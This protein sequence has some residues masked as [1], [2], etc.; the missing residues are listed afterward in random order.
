M[1]NWKLKKNTNSQD[2][3]GKTFIQSFVKIGLITLKRVTGAQTEITQ[4]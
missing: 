1:E 4:L 3:Q 2:R